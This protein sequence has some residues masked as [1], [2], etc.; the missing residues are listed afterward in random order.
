METLVR[1][2]ETRLGTAPVVGPDLPFTFTAY[3]ETEMGTGLR[4]R[5]LVFPIPRPFPEL[6][7]WKEWAY[8]DEQR[9]AHNQKRLVNVDPG[10]L[11]LSHLVLASFKPFSH[12]LY[13]GNG[14]HAEITLIFH[15][16]PPRWESLP[17]TY[18][19]YRDPRVQEFLLDVRQRFASQLKQEG[20]P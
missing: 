12:R 2:W 14:V 3:Y 16:K 6:V 15:R 5:W 4:K 17:W 19:D 11:G 8:S 13:L 7:T 20:P 1:E 10:W 18:A 9:Y